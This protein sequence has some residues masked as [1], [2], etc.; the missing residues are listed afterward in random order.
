MAGGVGGLWRRVGGGGGR[1]VGRS[2]QLPWCQMPQ[3]SGPKLL[4]DVTGEG[5]PERTVLRPLAASGDPVRVCGT[6]CDL[7]ACLFT[8][9]VQ[10]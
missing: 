2:G 5:V 6:I 10:L 9:V 3:G 4:S 1:A 8:F 7:C